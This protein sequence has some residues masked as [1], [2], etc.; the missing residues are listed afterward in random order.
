ME[1]FQV[2]VANAYEIQN[3]SN[4][5]ISKNGILQNVEVGS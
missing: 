3:I 1:K 4:I 5:I 2:Q